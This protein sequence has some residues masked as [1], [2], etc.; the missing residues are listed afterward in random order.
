MYRP[1]D[2]CTVLEIFPPLYTVSWKKSL[3]YSSHTFITRRLLVDFRNH[4][5]VTISWKFAI[6]RLLNIPWHLKRVAGYRPRVF[7]SIYQ[8]PHRQRSAAALHQA[9]LQLIHIIHRL[10]LCTQIIR[11]T[12]FSFFSEFINCLVHFCDCYRI[13]HCKPANNE[14]SSIYLDNDHNELQ[15]HLTSEQCQQCCLGYDNICQ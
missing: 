6:K 2:V 14:A 7:F 1:Y 8:S 15:F 9:L 13:Q 11:T 12:A 5:T 10:L 4:F 3:H